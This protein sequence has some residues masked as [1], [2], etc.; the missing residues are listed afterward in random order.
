[1]KVDLSVESPN[2]GEFKNNFVVISFRHSRHSNNPKE[3]R[4]T[5]CSIF[6]ITEARFLS[7]EIAY[8]NPKDNF[9]RAVGRKVSLEKA[10]GISK[11]DKDQ[12]VRVMTEYF[13][14]FKHSEK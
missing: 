5:I 4:V 8:T 1:M 11:L 6:S 12:R 9:C 3:K 2:G 10:L 13:K 7:T 14:H